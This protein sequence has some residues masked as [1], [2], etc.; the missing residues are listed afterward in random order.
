MAQTWQAQ[1]LLSKEAWQNFEPLLSDLFDAIVV[2]PVRDQDPT[3]PEQVA[4]IF[5]DKPDEADL[6]A[7]LTA[8]AEACGV[9]LPDITIEALPDIDWLQHVYENLKPIEAGRFFVHGSHIQ[10]DLPQDKTCIIIEAASA[11]GTGEHPTT[12]G[13]LTALDR[14]LAQKSPQKILDMGTGSGI[15]AIAVAAV[16]PK[17]N[18]IAAVDIDANSV[19][20]A[21]NH[22]ADN[23]V[24]DRILFEAGDGCRAPIV[25]KHAPYDLVL[26]NILAQPL[27]DMAADLTSVASGDIILSGFT[28]TQLPYVEKHYL[29]NGCK[30]VSVDQIEEWVTLWLR[31]E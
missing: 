4:L 1:F 7:Q 9:E 17:T 6:M 27:M 11:F 18:V 16:V 14:L 24:E 19:R 23:K 21:R 15:L 3:S 20:V 28:E 29:A 13:C 10:Q 8:L 12:K 22:A 26:A 31:K 5:A 2:K 25:G 30:R